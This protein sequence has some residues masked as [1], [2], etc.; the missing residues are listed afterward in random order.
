MVDI[1][2]LPSCGGL[3]AYV[4]PKKQMVSYGWTANSHTVGSPYQ[5]SGV[6]HVRL[7]K[8]IQTTPKEQRL[9]KEE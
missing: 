8:T 7:D 6:F 4:G 5:R 1:A 2:G 3:W 9:P